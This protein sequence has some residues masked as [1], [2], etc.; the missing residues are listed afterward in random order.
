[1]SQIP[2]NAL[3]SAA[4]AAPYLPPSAAGEPVSFIRLSNTS[5]VATTWSWAGE[6]PAQSVSLSTALELLT[7]T[8]SKVNKDPTNATAEAVA[9]TQQDVH[10]FRSW[11]YFPHFDGPQLA[12]G[13]YAKFD[14]LQGVKKTYYASGLNAFEDVEFAVRAGLDIVS[15]YF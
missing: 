15:T 12:S 3:Y 5:N 8:L 9:V 7:S 4:S 2:A 10:A 1:M 6:A 13:V 11:D 14:A